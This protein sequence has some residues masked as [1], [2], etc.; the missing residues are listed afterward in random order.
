MKHIAVELHEFTFKPNIQ[1]SNKN[2]KLLV[3]LNKPL[4]IITIVNI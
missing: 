3:V 2:I 4:D 1:T